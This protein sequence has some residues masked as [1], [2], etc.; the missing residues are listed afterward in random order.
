MAELPDPSTLKNSVHP[1]SILSSPTDPSSTTGR[2]PTSAKQPP[3]DV[4]T[5]SSSTY[6]SQ[7]DSSSTLETSSQY[8]GLVEL[9]GRVSPSQRSVSHEESS[10]GQNNLGVSN[11]R[12]SKRHL[13]HTESSRSNSSQRESSSSSRGHSASISSS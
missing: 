12:R 5:C 3:P 1:K 8:S 10:S 9:S 6:P 11:L 13:S 4:L 2:L 7:S